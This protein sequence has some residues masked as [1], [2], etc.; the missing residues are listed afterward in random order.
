MARRDPPA[1]QELELMISG[2]VASGISR[3]EI[4]RRAGLTR[5]TV[6][7]YKSGEIRRP[8][9]DSYKRVQGVYQAMHVR[10]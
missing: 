7:R 8:S 10:K 1:S 5:A 4:A 3:A 2:L 6:S 9:A